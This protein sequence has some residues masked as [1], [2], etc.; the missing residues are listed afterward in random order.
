M[1][2]EEDS[3]FGEDD[4]ATL[5]S[6]RDTLGELVDPSTTVEAQEYSRKIL[7]REMAGGRGTLEQGLLT[8]M[9]QNAEQA[10]VALRAARE[11]LLARRYNP[12]EAWLAASAA[13]SRPSK[14]G[15]LGEAAGKLSSGLLPVLQKR[16]EFD[17]N[18]DK[19]VLGIDAQL[20]GLDDKVL[21]QRLLMLKAQGANETQLAKEALKTLGKRP[22]ANTTQK[23]AVEAVDKAYAPDYVE[24]IQTGASDAAKGLEELEGARDR[25]RGFRVDPE[26]GEM[27]PLVK[28]DRLTG[29]VV[30][31]IA[32][33]PAGVGKWAQDVFFP[34]SS[35]VQETVE[36]TIQRS[37]R[38][39]LGA[40]FTKE[41]GER[42][43]SRVYNPRLEE[44]VNAQRIDRLVRQLKRAYEE[45]VRAAKY[46]EKNNTLLGFKGKTT[47]ALSDF[48]PDD[49]W[50]GEE[51][52]L[53]EDVVDEPL[54]DDDAPAID[55]NAPAE[56][57]VEER[58]KF[59]DLPRRKQGLIP[60][61][62]RAL[63]F[64][65]GG[66]VKGKIAVEMPDGRVI[67][68]PPGTTQEDL[69]GEHDDLDLLGAGW[70]G[71]LGAGAGY[72]GAK[73]ALK[74]GTS[75]MDLVPGHGTTPAEQRLLKLLEEADTAPD[76]WLGQV[77][78]ARRRGVPARA[79]DAGPPAVRDLAEIAL[80]SAGKE[81]SSLT[82]ELADRQAGA[83][84]RTVDQVNKGLKPDE[85]FSEEEKLL[86]NLYSNSD[87]LYKA[88]Y[89]AF[90]EI[91]SKEILKLME[92][93]AGKKAVKEAVKAMKNKGQEIGKA[94][95][96]G[97]VRKPSLEFLDIVKRKLGD[98]IDREEG[99]GP[100]YKATDTGRD[101]RALRNRLLSELDTATI[102]DGKSLYGEAR[103]QYAG[104]NEVLEALRLGREEFGRLAPEQIKVLTNKMSFA[105]K[106]AF[107]SGVAQKLFETL[108]GPSQD[109]A[110]A[111]RLVGSPE[112]V[113]KLEPL[114]DTPQQFRVFKEALQMEAEM[115]DHSKRLISTG[116]TA[117]RRSA[118]PERSLIERGAAKAPQLGVFSPTYWALKILREKP[119]MKP[120]EAT[121]IIEMLR[122][123]EPDEL[124]KL[125][126]NLGKKFGRTT[127]RAGRMG[128]A[129][130]IGAAVGAISGALM[131]GEEEEVD[132]TLEGL[133]EEEV[134][135]AQRPA[136]AKGGSV[137]E[138]LAS[139]R[140]R[141]GT[142]DSHN[143]G[144][145]RE[146]DS[147]S[148][149]FKVSPARVWKML[150]L[151]DPGLIPPQLPP[152][153][154]PE[155]I[156]K[157]RAEHQAILD[158]IKYATGM[159]PADRERLNQ[160]SLLATQSMDRAA[161]DMNSGNM[162]QVEQLMRQLRDLSS[163]FKARGGRI[164]G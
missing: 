6:L 48:M 89:A 38:P 145:R 95:A 90:P 14:F 17:L 156:A 133:T 65:E 149:T 130:K 18:R 120:K 144:L 115:F 64:A 57:V 51:G 68:V 13:L 129:G 82:T 75:I 2:D 164:H 123:G 109:I 105:E 44:G 113:K 67:Y 21:L 41:E 22:P 101:L 161:G 126:K 97:M 66:G 56:E 31:S 7:D 150:E 131:G 102:K 140:K 53:E 108:E 43:I 73:T 5:S 158:R 27:V 78:T 63:G 59:E 159:M 47:W 34:K 91:D 153:P 110:A 50:P 1:E 16:N 99:S 111:Q 19:E 138:A 72:L 127:K 79:L 132:P 117:R 106:D 55:P 146:V 83:R 143:P 10:R 28:N 107:R 81:G 125:G 148:D 42:L 23:K 92:T 118:G 98:A 87:P 124:A 25:L 3:V 86:S 77:R 15:T 96:M 49:T 30:G 12:G 8:K 71:A 46:Y 139:I 134:D 142:L 121:E 74:T 119:Q 70:K 151:A 136:L 157:Q 39:I 76:K 163:G 26:S 114:F 4:A 122:A 29:P 152:R 62:R 100:N 160:A 60:R 94:D 141:F 85:F 9:E 154:D 58:V 11:K 32:T 24:F 35:D 61:A 69:L 36:Y 80:G 40:Q 33:L 93:P 37:L 137:M 162:M 20:A 104:D 103:A 112:M 135:W 84:E 155:M 45:K 52:F 147:V 54:S 128:K 116:E 88:A